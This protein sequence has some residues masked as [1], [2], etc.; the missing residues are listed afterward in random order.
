MKIRQTGEQDREDWDTLFEAYCAFGGERQ[1]PEMRDRVWGWIHDPSAQTLCFV[2]ENDQDEL[3]GFVHF[4]S[5]ERPMPATKGAYIDDMFVTASA[6]G[7]GLVGKMIEA[8]GAYA[9]EQGWDVVR[10]MT[11]ETNYRAR[12]VYDRHATKSNWITYQ[13][14]T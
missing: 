14:N 3:V 7:Q 10:W 12:S 1:T 11:S 8:V 9:R 2:A 6:R 13:L 4:R 5:Y